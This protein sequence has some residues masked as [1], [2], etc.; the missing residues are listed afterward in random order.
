[1]LVS[2]RFAQCHAGDLRPKGEHLLRGTSTPQALF[3]LA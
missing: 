3:A 1:V 2:A